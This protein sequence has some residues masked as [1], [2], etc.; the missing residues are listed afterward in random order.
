MSQPPNLGMLFCSSIFQS[1]HKNQEVKNCGKNCV[2]CPYLLKTSL[3]YF[4]RVNNTFFL[5]NSGNFKSSNLTSVA[6]CQGFKQ[7]HIRK[8]GLVNKKVNILVFTEEI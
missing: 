2:S 8:T 1:Q 5:K 6:I 7:A 3:Y 4:K